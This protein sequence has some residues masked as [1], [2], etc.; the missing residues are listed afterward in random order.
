VGAQ[1][2][3]STIPKRITPQNTTH[4]KTQ[5]KKVVDYYK[6]RVAQIVADRSQEEVAAQIRATLQK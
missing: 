6:S 4:K 2:T 5:Q 1:H 3:Q